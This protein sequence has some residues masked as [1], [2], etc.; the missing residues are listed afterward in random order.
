MIVTAW[1]LF[2]LLSPGLVVTIPPFEFMK[3]TTNNLAVLVHSALFF[4]ALKAIYVN[5]FGLFGYL[6]QAEQQITGQSF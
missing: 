6:A 5:A 4:A 3:E 1:L 2:I